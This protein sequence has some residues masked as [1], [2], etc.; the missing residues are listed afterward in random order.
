MEG[1][2]RTESYTLSTFNT[3]VKEEEITKKRT[4]KKPL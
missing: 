2:F 1:G 4:E 3:L